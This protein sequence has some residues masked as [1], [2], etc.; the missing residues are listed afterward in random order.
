MA[1]IRLKIL[2]KQPR[3]LVASVQMVVSVQNLLVLQRLREER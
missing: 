2:M 1:V 3:D